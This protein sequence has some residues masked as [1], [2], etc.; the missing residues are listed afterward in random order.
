MCIIV[1]KPAKMPMV[2]STLETCFAN[3]PDGAGFM[4][5][6]EGRLLIKKGYFEFDDFWTAWEKCQKI[7]GDN[8]PVIFHFRIATAGVVDKANCHPHR[9]T[10]DLGFVHN[11]IL[12]CV[13][14]P[15]DSSISD[16]IIYRNRYFGKLTGQSLHSAKLYGTIARHIGEG[17]KFAFMNG[18]GKVVI[19]NEKQGVWKDNLWFSNFSYLPRRVNQFL[20]FDG[21][22]FCEYCGKLLESAEE[23]TEGACHECLDYF[24][25]GTA[26]CGGCYGVLPSFAHRELGWCDDCG[27]EIYGRQWSTMLRQTARSWAR[28]KGVERF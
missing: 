26:E 1:Y 3:N 6:C 25:T 4:F 27:F 8:L 18:G 28:D 17:N 10:H 21:A 11:G 13:D 12:A 9:I 7:H 20:V 5:P 14:V 24:E 15:K 2:C 23:T 16:T 19:C 22:W